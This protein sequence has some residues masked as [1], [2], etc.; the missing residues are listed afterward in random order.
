[1][2]KRNLGSGGLRVSAIGLGCMGMS[3]SYG[4]PAD[5]REMIR[6]VRSAAERGVTMFD[7]AEVYG[8]HINEE[9][10]GE[11]LVPVRGEVAI[12]T[13]FGFKL[14][15]GPDHPSGRW[16][17]AGLDSRPAHIREVADASLRRLKTDVID[18][19]YQHRVDPDVPIEEVAGAVG[20]LVKEGKVKYFGLCEAD[21]ET[22]R[23]A[24]SAYPVAAVQSEYSLW[25]RQPERE[26]L[27]VLNELGIG[28]VPFSPLGK[29]FLTGS[30]DQRAR[31]SRRETSAIP[32]RD[33]R[34]T[35]AP[36]TVRWWMC[37]RAWRNGRTQPR[38]RSRLPGCLPKGPRSCQ[39]PA[40][41][42]SSASR[43][44]L[45]RLGSSSARTILPRLSGKAQP[46]PSKAARRRCRTS[47][48]P[49]PSS[50]TLTRTRTHPGWKTERTLRSAVPC[51]Q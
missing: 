25:T 15:G 48:M 22:I 31:P 27:P 44:T 26:V 5:R 24:H 7:T 14:A 16:T 19:F 35:P 41:G 40:R 23:R 36:R 20:E 12:A 3:F 37:W 46:S 4:P 39:F 49:H 13:K 2:D 30:I 1:M 21:A 33:S 38:P 47:L 34:K 43:K 8:P 18:L 9:L 50:P 6:L 51:S 28:F 11:A 45:E 29:G 42:R 17:W 32:C 10:V